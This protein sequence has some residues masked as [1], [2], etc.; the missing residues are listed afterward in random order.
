MSHIPALLKK[1]PLTLLN[2]GG[3]NVV[4]E[5]S[6]VIV[7]ISDER[8]AVMFVDNSARKIYGQRYLDAPGL[9]AKIHRFT[10][11]VMSDIEAAYRQE[12]R[13]ALA[14]GRTFPSQE[15]ALQRIKQII[16]K[17]VQEPMTF[18]DKAD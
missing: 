12:A 10:D 2:A 14:E 1:I 3:K 4:V 8:A 16:D 6:A 15:P 7:R 17:H 11:G 13:T 5:L 9:D 18:Q